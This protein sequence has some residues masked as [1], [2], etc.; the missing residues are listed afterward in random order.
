MQE[1]PLRQHNNSGG[2]LPLPLCQSD[3]W[4]ELRQ[5]YRE[6]S[7]DG[8]LA[9]SHR[10][11]ALTHSRPQR[12]WCVER[13][14]GLLWSDTSQTSH[15]SL[16]CPDIQHFSTSVVHVFSIGWTGLSPGHS[17]VCVC[18]VLIFLD[19][20][21]SWRSRNIHFAP[22]KVTVRRGALIQ[23]YAWYFSLLLGS[24]RRKDV[25]VWKARHCGL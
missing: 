10:A 11:A 2:I 15:Y 12:Q 23:L 5:Q 25:R 17:S 1:L 24:R 14:R 4:G 18:L 6:E 13:R 22:F 19:G 9:A 7:G 16:D 21:L 3:Q 8:V 20:T